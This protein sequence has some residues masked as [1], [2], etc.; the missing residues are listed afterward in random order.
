[1]AMSNY[2]I[3]F[4]CFRAT[5]FDKDITPYIH[6]F[7]Y[8]AHFFV[9]KFGELKV[10]ETEGLEHLNLINKLVYF[11]ATN[12]G[13]ENFTITEQVPDIVLLSNL[14]ACVNY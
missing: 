11:G 9:E 3:M 8:H 1:M 14:C 6:T 12:H 10:F 2:L 5:T 7:V 4:S 13:K